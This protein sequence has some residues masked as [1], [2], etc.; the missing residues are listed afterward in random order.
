M[1][2]MKTL[3]RSFV[4]SSSLAAL[5]CPA[6][7]LAQAPAAKPMP[8]PPAD[9]SAMLGG[10]KVSVHY[11]AP[12]LRGR[13]MIGEHEPYGKVWR[14]GANPATMFV[15]ETDLKVGDLMLPAG[16]YTIFT[17]PQAPGTPWTLIINKETGQWGLA[18]KEAMDFGRTPM[19]SKPV[20]TPQEV[21]SISFEN[22]HGKKAEL[23]IKWADL[24]EWVPVEAK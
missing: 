15:T 7:L 18:Y 19:M 24:D 16:K 12:S 10:K 14:T 3:L 13:K 17:I 5:C 21:M 8:S 1:G 23:H 2:R 6:V 11:N 9:A 4:L 20:S 22:V